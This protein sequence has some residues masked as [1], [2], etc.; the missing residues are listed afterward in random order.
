MGN[1]ESGLNNEEVSEETKQIDKTEQENI[2]EIFEELYNTQLP[3]ILKIYGPNMNSIQISELV[4]A[5]RYS[6]ELLHKLFLKVR[7][8]NETTIEEDLMITATCISPQ[9]LGD[10]SFEKEMGIKCSKRKSKMT[11]LVKKL[12]DVSYE[13]SVESTLDRK[14]D[15][16]VNALR[17]RCDLAFKNISEENGFTDNDKVLFLA[18]YMT[19]V[20]R[21]EDDIDEHE[22]EMCQGIMRHVP[23]QLKCKLN[24]VLSV[25]E[26]RQASFRKLLNAGFNEN[27][28]NKERHLEHFI[29]TGK[30]LLG[31]LEDQLKVGGGGSSTSRFLKSSPRHMHILLAFMDAV[32]SIYLI[33]DTVYNKK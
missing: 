7:F 31:M 16:S 17:E 19:E 9:S 29:E 26:S 1:A 25:I 14:D 2:N 12:R 24:V 30:F 11:E 22:S 6:E 21:R 10:V 27:G 13:I 18:E 3:S 4:L 8:A 28:S 33:V 23:P 5:L 32:S 15:D 20:L